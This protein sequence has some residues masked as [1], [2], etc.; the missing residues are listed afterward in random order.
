MADSR[1]LVELV[2]SSNAAKC[3]MFSNLSQYILTIL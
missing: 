2:D 3:V 1:G